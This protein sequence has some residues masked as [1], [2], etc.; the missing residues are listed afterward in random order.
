MTPTAE[1]VT[2]L[3][4]TI[5]PEL[6]EEPFFAYDIPEE[7]RQFQQLPIFKVSTV[8]ETN[9]TFGS[10]Q[11]NSRNYRIQIMI[12]IDIATTDIEWLND[13]LDRGLEKNNFIQ[14]YGEDQPHSENKKIHILIRQYTHTRR[15]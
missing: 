1:I 12:F 9:G 10:N 8:G 7:Y 2:E 11:Y 13:T 4:P 3:L 14:V 5:F 6:K 15:K